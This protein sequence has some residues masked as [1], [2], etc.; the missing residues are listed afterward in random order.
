VIRSESLAELNAALSAAQGEFEAV[1]KT[2]NNPFFKSKYAALPDV[3]KAATP[4]LAKNGL[5]VW[6]GA[7]MTDDMKGEMLW[8]VVLHSSGQ[9]IG[10]AARMLPMEDKNGVVTPQAQG[11]ATS[12]LRRYQ[13]MAALGLVADV[14]DDAEAAM[15]RGRVI[16]SAGQKETRKATNGSSNS[17]EARSE[18]QDASES[19]SRTE[20]V[21]DETLK[22]LGDAYRSA[23]ATASDLKAILKEVGAEGT[24]TSDLSEEK[25]TWV[26]I[27]LQEMA[28]E[29]AA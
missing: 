24:K 23:G 6:Q 22:A 27:K 21:T 7:D 2:A 5:A 26:V 12:Y 18:A 29:K 25:A 11:S 10:S 1:S 13:Y 17:Q 15:P 20:A 14:D 3:V 8:T 9:Y 4:I 19:T 28:K 16:K